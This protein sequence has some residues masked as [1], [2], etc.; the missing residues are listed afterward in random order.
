[1]KKI[2]MF[3]LG[4]ML[5]DMY[6]ALNTAVDLNTAPHKKPLTSRAGDCVRGKSTIFLEVNN[7]RAMLLNSGDLWWDRN[8]AQYEAPKRTE[9]QVKN[10]VRAINPLFAGS[11]WV[12]GLV[13]GNLRMA[14]I[15]YSANKSAWWP[16]PIKQG[17]ATINKAKCEKFD[18]YWSVTSEEINDAIAGIK[19]SQSILEWPGRGNRYLIN[20]KKTFTAEE[21]SDD[22]APFYDKNGNCVYDPELGDL[23]SIKPVSNNPLCTSPCNKFTYADQMIFW[24]INDVGNDH[25]NPASTPIGA[26]MNCLAF[27]FKSSD[28]LNDM[29]FYTYDVHNKS[30]VTLEQ[31]YMSQFMDADLGNYNDDY[32]GCDVTRSMGFVY[33]SDDYDENA[34][35]LGYLDQPPIFGVDFFEGPKKANGLPIGLSS[36][37][38]FIN[39]QGG[40]VNDPINEPQTRNFQM[41]FASNG[42]S[43]TVSSDCITP[44]FPATKFCFSGDPAKPGEWSMCDRNFTPRDL[45]WLQNSGPFD[46]NSGT[47]ETITIGC[48]YVRPPKGSQTGCRPVM[49][50]LQE[51]DDKAQRLFDFCFEKSPGPDAPNLKII[52]TPKKLFFTLENP[53]GSNNFGENYNLK[54]IDVPLGTWNN[55]STY[56]FEGYAIY[57][58]VSENAVS[59]LEDLK[60]N[61]K[62]KLLTI[63]DKKNSINRGVNY[64]KEV[65]NGQSVTV[66][67]QDLALPNK[68]I[69]REIVVD[70]DLFQ[71]EGQTFL[72]NNKTYYY[73]TVAFAY[74]NYRNPTIPTEVQQNQLIFS[75]AIKI[76]KGTPHN[77]DFW[78]V[79]TKADYYQGIPV[80]R[81]SGQGHGKYFLDLEKGEEEKIL[82]NGSQLDLKYAG[83]KSPILVKV[84]DPFK[85]KNA[86]FNLSFSEVVAV[87]DPNKYDLAQ[88]S[89]TMDITDPSNRAIVSEGQLDRE[90]SQSIYAR[91]NGQLESYGIA[92]A[93]TFPDTL[94]T[95]SRNGNKFYSY[96]DGSIGFKD[97]SKK[98]LSL[99]ADVDGV[100]YKDWIR[101][102]AVNDVRAKNASAYNVING[103][104]VWTDSVGNFA[105]VLGGKF[106]PYCLAANSN[107]TAVAAENNYQSFS[108]G[109]K[110]R[111]VAKDSLTMVTWG[112]GPENTLDSIYSLDLVITNEKTK[113][114]RAVVFETGESELFTEGNALKG[115]LRQ[116]PGVGQDG[117]PDGS[118]KGLGWFPGYAINLETGVRMNVYFGENS[119]FRG[120][121]AANMVWDPDSTTETVLG[122]PIFGGSQFVYVMNTAYDNGDRA[123]LDRKLLNDNFNLTNGVG[124]NA[125]LNANVAN[126]YRQIAWTC[127]PLTAKNFSMYNAA[128]VY[129]IPTEVRIKVR[130]EKPYAKYAGDASIYEFSTEGLE[131]V[132]S[133]SLVTSAFDKMTVVPNPYY[134]F[135]SYELNATQNVVKIVNVPKN[136]VVSIFTTDGI[137]VR[138][139]K[140]DS[141][142]IVDGQYGD[143]SGNINYDNTIDWD[144]RTSTGVMVASGVYYI[145]VEAPNV[146]TKV[147]KLFAIMRAADVSNF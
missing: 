95:I 110:W 131:P 72:A 41:G 28:Q 12:S 30:N 21:L 98:W 42:S 58:I 35:T 143:N 145:N 79:K 100:D 60:D 43:L 27:A 124:A 94:G 113:W 64:R 20:V 132:K 78:G 126:F 69:E 81:K 105:K 133:D 6:A 130:V 36:F 18:Q 59:N 75:N 51:A 44:G 146:G 86:K 96:I 141:K 116:S 52:E 119:R 57:Q 107:V 90:F 128:G 80:T 73:A 87:Q 115:Q 53:V 67:T 55:D 111:R 31:T 13:G 10:K 102:G 49:S 19:I 50:Y 101:S 92:V 62:A 74:N 66:I 54:N 89:W 127:F 108:P 82:T 16:G 24:V 139:L 63:M 140:L 4:V 71:F 135:S 47:K 70:R 48:V 11:V 104:R 9:E 39:G 85:L 103:R 14:A 22:L 45:R 23:P 123:A 37:N 83:G 138:R 33:N 142:G 56:K 134:A 109:F 15:T 129:E 5:G 88:T 112:E 125:T 118:D 91:I 38:Y 120:K 114:S 76:F 136:S 97:S 65:V 34:T 2:L 40:L 25:V 147:L 17:E 122:N 117:Q 29:T 144:L 32:V 137:L 3:V 106:A 84:I 8:T 7:I 61:S 1:M 68:G 26:Q 77:N 93:T 121:N 99:L 46:M